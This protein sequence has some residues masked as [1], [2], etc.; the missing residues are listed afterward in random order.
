MPP[1]ADAGETAPYAVLAR[2]DPVMARLIG[3]YGTPDPFEFADGGRSDGSNFAAMA[4]HIIAQQI[5]TKVA[6]GVFDR[7]AAASGGTPDPESILRLSVEELR[8]L[9]TSHSKAS[10][11]RALAQSVQSGELAIDRLGDLPD[12]DAADALTRVKGIGPWSAEMFLIHQLKRTDVLPAGD[13]GIRVAIQNAYALPDVP[14]I[15]DVELRGQAWIPYRTF[16]AAV[17]WRSLS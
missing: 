2:K 10:Y 15:E 13:R 4:L 3:Q 6:L 16:A 8:A 11:L 9:G 12:Q 14:S 17:L 1:E 5:S 7:V